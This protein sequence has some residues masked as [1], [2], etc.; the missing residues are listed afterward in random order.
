MFSYK[1]R[2]VFSVVIWS[3]FC[4]GLDMTTIGKPHLTLRFIIRR[5]KFLTVK[6]DTFETYSKKTFRSFLRYFP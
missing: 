3:E 2:R 5:V 1:V 4:M 6:M